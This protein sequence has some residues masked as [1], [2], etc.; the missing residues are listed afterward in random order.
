M[1]GE[2]D[3]DELRAL[4]V[5]CIDGGYPYYA[6][7]GERGGRWYN[8]VLEIL[9]RIGWKMTHLT[10]LGTVAFN[11]DTMNQ[12]IQFGDPIIG[13]DGSVSWDTAVNPG[14]LHFGLWLQFVPEPF[15]DIAASQADRVG[16][17]CMGV[18]TTDA[19]RRSIIHQVHDACYVRVRD[20]GLALRSRP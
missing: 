6:V 3:T 1:A 10:E 17:E 20:R 12:L 5:E 14:V 9:E 15:R 18:P 19:W 11:M 4:L 7:L 8:R 2:R 16:G 13:E